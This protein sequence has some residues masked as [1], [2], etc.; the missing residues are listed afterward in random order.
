MDQHNA[1]NTTANIAP[2]IAKIIFDVIQQYYGL[3]MLFILFVVCPFTCFLTEKCRQCVAPSKFRKKTKM[4]SGEGD[5]NKSQSGFKRYCDHIMMLMYHI[6]TRNTKVGPP[7]SDFQIAQENLIENL[8][9][10]LRTPSKDE[11]NNSTCSSDAHDQNN[12]ENV[13]TPRKISPTHVIKGIDDNKMLKQPKELDKKNVFND[14]IK[15]SMYHIEK[16]INNTEDKVAHVQ[17]IVLPKITVTYAHTKDLD[18]SNDSVF[19]P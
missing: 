12:K 11:N 10:G 5:K 6:A 9:Q 3:F 8:P 18:S 15:K 4:N 2:D 14:Q 13:E 7:S 1:Y 16:R 17:I 19:L